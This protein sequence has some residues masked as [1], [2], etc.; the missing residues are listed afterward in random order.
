MMEGR[1]PTSYTRMDKD[2]QQYT[3]LSM[4]EQVILRTPTMQPSS[5]LVVKKFGQE[6]LATG[7][8]Y[9]L[10]IALEL[11]AMVVPRSIKELIQSFEDIFPKELHTELPPMRDIQHAVD[12]IPG[13]ALPNRAANSMTPMENDQLNRR[14][15]E[16]LDK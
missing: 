13:S 16:L 3:L 7:V 9:M 14:V 10:F 8:V 1:T 15:Q 4:K 5:L 2:G 12:F 6:T 11:D